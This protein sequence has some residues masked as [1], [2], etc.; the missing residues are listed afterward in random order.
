MW[1]GVCADSLSVDCCGCGYDAA[2]V[3]L[4][5]NIGGVDNAANVDLLR[6]SGRGDLSF[7]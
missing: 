7:I 5:I 3:V 6:A 4:D 2:K 1:E